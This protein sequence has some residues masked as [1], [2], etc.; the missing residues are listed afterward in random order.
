MS[1]GVFMYK[2]ILIA[3]CSIMAL[4]TV[5]YLIIFSVSTNEV[6]AQAAIANS[7]KVLVVDTARGKI[8]DSNFEPL[9][10]ETD[11]Y[12]AAVVPTQE[13]LRALLDYTDEKEHN[14]IY[15]LFETGQPFLYTVDTPYLYADGITMITSKER[16][17][18]QQLAA[19]VIGHL[20]G[21]GNGVSG[22]EK[23]YNSV[24]Q[25]LSSKLQV[26]YEVDVWSIPLVNANPEIR[27]TDYDSLQGIVLTIDKDIQRIVEEIGAQ[28][29][30]KGA[31]VIMDVNSGHIKA[32]ASFPAYN[33]NSVAE[34]LNDQ[35]SPLINRSTSN[36]NVGSIFKLVVMAAALEAG[37][38]E[39]YS[40]VCTGSITVDGVTF[41]CHNQ[42]GHGELDM[43][44]A[45]E[46][47]CNPYYINLALNEIGSARVYQTAV[48]LGFGT[49][50][51]LAGEMKTASGILP[52]LEQLENTGEF[53][54]F[55]FGQGKLMATP[56]QIGKLVC[57]I[58]NGGKLVN[59]TV[60]LGIS[61]QSGQSLL[62]YEGNLAP[63]Q[64]MHEEVAAQIKGFMENVVL[65]GSGT[66]A[67]PEYGGAGGKTGSAQ[68]GIYN[69][70]GE[71]IVHA[72]FAGF[73]PAD[74]P[75]YAVVILNEAG[76]SG[77]IYSAPIFKEIADRINSLTGYKS[78]WHKQLDYERKKMEEAE[79]LE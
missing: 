26:A 60:S 47:S 20:D 76:D 23:A 10:N 50:D 13:A 74:Q 14:H 49:A 15:K 48:N 12:T 33:P 54:N 17:S 51:E 61:D 53:A 64:V 27:D 34:S 8:Y 71:E 70:A 6:L 29:I 21:D 78:L 3:M 7:K 55:S 42:D 65:D 19:H 67:L 66:K 62:Q 28:Y 40:Y 16:Y 75:K 18:D 63:I 39:D 2:R 5:M 56:I 37:I 79:G 46:V 41:N 68:T 77:A 9:V 25:D 32:S 22:I 69:D 73:F 24:P 30:D 43:G 57:A 58:A 31:I 11:R 44:R 36:F 38:P 59:P 4:F 45:A 72:W 1:L 35:D 52:S